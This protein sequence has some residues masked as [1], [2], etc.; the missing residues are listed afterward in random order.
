MDP[1]LV[2]RFELTPG[3]PLGDT[4][5]F[6]GEEPVDGGAGL[7]EAKNAFSFSRKG[8]MLPGSLISEGASTP[9]PP[10]PRHG[11]KPLP[12]PILHSFIHSFCIR[13]SSG[14][15][16]YLMFGLCLVSVCSM[17]RNGD[18]T[19]MAPQSLKKSNRKFSRMHKVSDHRSI[20]TMK[21]IG[22]EVL[23]LG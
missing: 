11:W 9:T 6:L 7:Q 3:T 5:G 12:L 10:L 2:G 14:L 16:A 20:V 18:G 1:L 19:I 8:A 15:R 13:C 4:R 22:Y 21:G 23:R 17:R